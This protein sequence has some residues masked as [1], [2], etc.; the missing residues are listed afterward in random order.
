MHIQNRGTIKKKHI[1]MNESRF[2]SNSIIEKLTKNE[3]VEPRLGHKFA[4]YV[5]LFD[6]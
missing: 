3:V 1:F 4:L 2:F 6:S 5:Y